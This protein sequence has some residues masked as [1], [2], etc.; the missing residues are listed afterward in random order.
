MSDEKLLRDINARLAAIPEKPPFEGF[1]PL[2]GKEVA[3]VIRGGSGKKDGFMMEFTDGTFLIVD[4]RDL[5]VGT[6]DPDGSK[7]V[8]IDVHVERPL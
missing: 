2:I 5:F 4:G 7:S 3:S 6:Y 1:R 8:K